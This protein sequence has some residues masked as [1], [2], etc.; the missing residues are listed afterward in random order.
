MV[1]PDNKS[2][3][4]STNLPEDLK[5]KKEELRLKAQELRTV[6]QELYN[7]K[8]DIQAKRLELRSNQEELEAK[9]KVLQVKEEKLRD[10]EKQLMAKDKEINHKLK[11]LAEGQKRLEDERKLLEMRKS[12]IAENTTDNVSLENIDHYDE[13]IERP[14]AQGAGFLGKAT[15]KIKVI[16]SKNDGESKLKAAALVLAILVFISIAGFISTNLLMSLVVGTGNEVIV[17]DLHDI[18][19]D[20]ARKSSRDIDLFVQQVEHQHH[21]E[22]P[23]N[24]IISQTPEPGRKT[25][26]NRTIEVV[27][28]LGPELIR[29]PHLDNI[30][31]REARLRLENVGL[32]MGQVLYRYSDRVD[33]DRIITSHPAAETYV[34]RGSEVS[35][36]VSLGDLPDA[37]DRHQRYRGLLDSID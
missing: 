7:H 2:D 23:Q 32:D 16:F 24:R 33:K 26:P 37:S 21:D 10:L 27:V 1:V 15:H 19:F 17:P 30:T 31:E 36:Y 22:I 9:N 34:H 29:V 20:V 4:G 11:N 12:S 25:K 18:H 8:E 14:A 5:Q 6:S 35:V 28:S 13:D 3:S